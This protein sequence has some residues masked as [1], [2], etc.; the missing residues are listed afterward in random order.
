MLMYV[1]LWYGLSVMEFI[2]T[3]SVSII[4]SQG[5]CHGMCKR[6]VHAQCMWFCMGRARMDFIQT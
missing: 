2:H 3:L 4:S 6:S 5:T 1:V